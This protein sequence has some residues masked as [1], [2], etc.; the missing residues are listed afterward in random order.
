MPRKSRSTPQ[1]GPPFLTIGAHMVGA[2]AVVVEGVHYLD[3]DF[4]A[5][6]VMIRQPSVWEC[7]NLFGVLDW[8]AEERLYPTIGD[9]WGADERSAGMDNFLL[10]HLRSPTVARIK[11]MKGTDFG[12]GPMFP[13]FT[14]ESHT[15]FVTSPL[16][17]L[18]GGNNAGLVTGPRGTF[19]DDCQ[20]IN[21]HV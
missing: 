8:A 2:T 13:Q 4:D 5:P 7:Y 18:R 11:A 1:P 17:W 9:A 19:L 15:L 6:V 14:Q 21:R 12:G 3:L 16:L 10:F 20:L